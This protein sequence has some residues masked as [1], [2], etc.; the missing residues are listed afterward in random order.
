MIV[1]LVA[2]VVGFLIGVVFSSLQSTKVAPQV[3]KQQQALPPGQQASGISPA[4]AS[5]ILALE[6]EVAA[7]PQNIEAWTS[8]GHVY[9]DTQRFAKAIN[10]YNKS[11]ALKPNNPDVLTDLG[12]MYRRNKQFN[13][14]LNA[15]DRATSLAPTHEQSRFNKGIVLL[16]D[17]KDKAAA[18]Q[19]WQELLTINPVALAPNGQSVK[20]LLATIE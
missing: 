14:A 6:N 3:V 4:Q 16:Y 5:Q 17:L 15:F 18:R 20:E 2:L 10:A 7:N 8:L 12:V 1:A 19:V 13:E 9:F 11:L